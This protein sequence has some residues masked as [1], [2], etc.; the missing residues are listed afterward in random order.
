MDLLNVRAGVTIKMLECYSSFEMSYS[1]ENP[2][3]LEYFG[4]EKKLNLA[5]LCFTVPC[6][7]SSLFLLCGLTDATFFP[8]ELLKVLWT[9][10]SSPFLSTCEFALLGGNRTILYKRVTTLDPFL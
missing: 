4:T 6:P 8:L 2:G 1:S 7:F 10:E 3:V 5:G 9:K